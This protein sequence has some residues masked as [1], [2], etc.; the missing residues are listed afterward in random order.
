M[1]PGIKSTDLPAPIAANTNKAGKLNINNSV[2][3]Q[4]LPRALGVLLLV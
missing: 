3:T 2:P 1:I 4:L